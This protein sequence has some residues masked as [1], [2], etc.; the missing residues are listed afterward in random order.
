VMNEFGT[1]PTNRKVGTSGP[2]VRSMVRI[3]DI[4]N[5]FGGAKTAR[6]AINKIY[7]IGETVSEAKGRDERP[8]RPPRDSI[9]T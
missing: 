8:V 6:L 1:Q 7:K 5:G 9:L 4:C 3:L 2:F